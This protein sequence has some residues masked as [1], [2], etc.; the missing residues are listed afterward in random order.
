MRTY[1]RTHPWINFTLDLNNARYIH[2]LMLGEAQSKCRHFE[3]V[4]LLPDVAKH[5]YS[6]YLAKGVSATTAIEGNTLTEDEV[7][8]RIEGKLELPASK[9]YMGQEIDNII[10]ACNM[11]GNHVLESETPDISIDTFKRY[12]KL[13]LKDLP[14]AEHVMPGEIRDYVVVVGPYKGAPSDDCEYLLSQLCGWINREL[15][16]PQEYRMAFGILKAVLAHLY[17]A[18]IHPFGDGNGRTARLIE[19]HLL[20]A[21]G[22]PTIAGHLLSNHYNQTRTEYYRQ[23]DLSHQA[24]NNVFSFLE[25]ALRGFI[26]GL[27]EQINVIKDQQMTVHWI[28]HVHSVFK[29]KDGAADLRRKRLVIDLSESDDLVPVSA[30]RYLSPRVAEGYAS[31]TDKTIQRDI[32]ALVEMDLITKSGSNIHVRKEKML[33]F[34]SP[35]RND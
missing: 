32:N 23:L 3:Q 18:W 4:P 21:A 29:D 10:E 33:A 16:A 17:L 7:L 19:L 11:I 1:E 24:E 13:V 20:L 2:W 5:L 8:R 34:I 31:K 6:I 12:N 15:D 22:V 9:D 35:V 30:I 14:L 26:D 28:N 25:Y 27:K